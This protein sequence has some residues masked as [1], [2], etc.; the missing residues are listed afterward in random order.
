MVNMS[1][2]HIFLSGNRLLSCKGGNKSFV[3][4]FADDT[5][6]Y[7]IFLLNFGLWSKWDY[8][9]ELKDKA[10]IIPYFSY[11]QQIP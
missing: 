4:H 3:P 10:G 5:I 1:Q 2:S 11:S 8:L 9:V 7:D 6:L